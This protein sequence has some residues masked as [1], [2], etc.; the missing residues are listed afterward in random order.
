MTPEEEL[1]LAVFREI[2]KKGFG[3]LRIVIRDGKVVRC[4]EV[5]LH[6]LNKR[7]KE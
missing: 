4:E 6:D 2:T 5:R 1:I 3:E 7:L